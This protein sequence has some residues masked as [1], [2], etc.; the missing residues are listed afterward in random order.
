MKIKRN[1]LFL[2]NTAPQTG[3]NFFEEIKLA[4]SK[5]LSENYSPMKSGTSRKIARNDVSSVGFSNLKKC[6]PIHNPL[7]GASQ[8]TTIS[9]DINLS[10]SPKKNFISPNREKFQKIR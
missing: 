3:I 10:D 4:Q 7:L 1:L 6:S 5:M 8:L 9:H 2:D